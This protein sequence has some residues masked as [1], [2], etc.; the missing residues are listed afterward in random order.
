MRD[1]IENKKRRNA[2]AQQRKFR[3]WF[4]SAKKQTAERVEEIGTET[5]DR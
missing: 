1:Q 5:P 3:E 2:F 4:E